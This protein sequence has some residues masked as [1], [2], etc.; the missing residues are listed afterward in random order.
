MILLLVIGL[1]TLIILQMHLIGLEII[2]VGVIMRET[3][4][5]KESETIELKTSTA[6]LEEAI[7]AI[8]AIL[9]KHKK[10]ELYFGIKNNGIAVGQDISDK[11]LRDISKTISDNIEPKIFPIV[12]EVE[13]DSKEAEEKGIDVSGSNRIYKLA[14]LSLDR[15]DY[16]QAFERAKESRNTYA[17]EVKGEMAKFSYYLKQNKLEFALGLLFLIIFGF[18]SY[19]LARYEM[20]KNRIRK[21]KEEEVILNQLIKLAQEETFKRRR[22]SMEEYELTVEHY[23]KKM[24]EITNLLIELENEK[25]YALTFM[26]RNKRLRVE[27]ARVIELIK[28]LQYAFVKKANM[29]PRMD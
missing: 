12:K 2:M 21:L 16:E 19:R 28:E 29:E 10:G 8:C 27:R 9:N 14:K 4:E 15:G 18:A 26:S 7:I 20:L 6:E 5:F 11:T 23:E 1:L 17:L 24:A 25:Q 3:M 22:M 13:I